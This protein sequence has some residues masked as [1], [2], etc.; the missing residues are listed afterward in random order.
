MKRD[1]QMSY[2]SGWEGNAGLP[3]VLFSHEDGQLGL[4]PAPELETLRGEHLI[5]LADVALDV[6]NLHLKAVRGRML[7][8]QLWA[9]IPDGESCGLSVFRSPDIQ[10]QTLIYYDN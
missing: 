10:E 5:D 9:R 1:P 6:A 4:K 2:D 3:I 7:E 8:I